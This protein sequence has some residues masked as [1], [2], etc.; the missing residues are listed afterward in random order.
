MPLNVVLET[1]DAEGLQQFQ[2]MQAD[3]IKA[4]SDRFYATHG[5]A[6][7]RF[8]V[9]GRE[10]CQED[11][12]FH[13]EFLRPVLEFGLLK[14]MVDYLHWL[15]S[16]LTARGI[17]TEHVALS[18]DWLAEY[19]VETMKSPHGAIVVHALQAVRAAFQGASPVSSPLPVLEAWPASAEFEAALLLGDQRSSLAIVNR[20]MDAGHS[21][22]EI[23]GHVIQPA[24]YAIGE[25]WQTNQVT[26]AQEHMATAV[27]QMVMVM[28]LLRSPLPT[29]NGKRVLLACVEGNQ[30]GVGVSMV[31]DAFQLAGWDV[32]YLGANV[33]TASLVQH[34]VET[35][36]DLVG[37]SVSFPQ[38]L[39]VVR[40]VIARF[41]A[42][43]GTARPPVI[44]GG[45]AINRFDRIAAILGADSS[46]VNAQ[47]AVTQALSMVYR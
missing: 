45:L 38:Q 23:E 35:R 5:S 43:L 4:V 16:V 24:M 2:A 12:A 37:L 30:H 11:I 13:L 21:L 40:D 33:P 27:A 3:A 18:L 22:V 29:P 1:L 25:K 7:Q 14:P 6:Y 20:L 36:P 17:P 8:G 19:V 10:A 42:Q 15:D 31:S 44:I 9:R 47:S 46:S 39:R 41:S 28:G 34:V 26:V 32:H